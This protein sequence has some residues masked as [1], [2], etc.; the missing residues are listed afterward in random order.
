MQ[1]RSISI[2]KGVRCD[3]PGLS[4]KAKIARKNAT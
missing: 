4:S 3:A 2:N 1:G